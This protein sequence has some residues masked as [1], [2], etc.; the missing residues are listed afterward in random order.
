LDIEK[1]KLRR[2]FVGGLFGGIL[3]TVILFVGTE[4]LGFPF[5]P[6]AIF[7]LLIAPVPGSIQ[8]FMVDTFREYAKYSAFVASSVIYAIMYGLI[9]VGLAFV[10]KGDLRAKVKEATLVGVVV[11]TVIGLGLQLELANAFPAI[12]SLFGW[13]L[14][15]I[16][17]V[18]VNLI[19]VKTVINYTKIAPAA[20]TMKQTP[21]AAISSA[22]RDVLKKAVVAAAVLVL[23]GVAAKIGLSILLK[24]PVVTSGTAIPVN[25]SGPT[26]PTVTS[27][28][29]DIFSDPRISNLVA[30]EVTDNR[31]FYRVDI[32][33][34]PPQLDFDTWRLN[35]HGKV[36]NAETLDKNTLLQ[37]ATVDEYGTLE[38][39][40][41]S[42]NPPAG[43]ISN[44]KWTGV[45][46]A[47]LLKQTGLLA[48]SNY[49]VFRCA[50]G[51]TVGVPIERALEPGALL[52]YK[53]NDVMLPN[54]HGFPLRAIV[55]GIYGMMNA[56]WI[57]E[58]E[59][60]DQ[61]YLGYWQERGWS[62][63]ARIKTTSIIYYPTSNVQV[64]SST[65]IA[66]VA[67]A[68]DR[69][70]SKVEVSVDGGNT[71]NEATLKPPCSPDSWV[72]WAYE[73]T[74]T[75]TGTANIIVRATDGQGQ[76]QDPTVVQPFPNGASG[77][78]TIQ[79]TV[80]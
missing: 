33:P 54:E 58:I 64:N 22:R 77:Y 61:V 74:P 24:Q 5:P 75:A 23:A 19:F 55:P 7:Q 67:F 69:G 30:S 16:L 10:F 63:D 34:I 9:A 39:V 47:T 50:D 53:M 12:S 18:A 51:Y 65:P 1:L 17:V 56:K 59:V 8:S 49:V 57:T 14:A 71:W 76:L 42:I 13:I 21:M 28:T 25:P 4:F 37:L 46:L 60:T 20:V 48:G 36:N 26:T 52:A 70:I 66:G 73:W 32:N 62:N 38:C 3:A 6:L 80:G 27:G 31:V 29:P 15:G 68:G 11:P 45:P 79:V 44:A 40:S 41:N 43:L 78:S 35:V 72:L 2:F